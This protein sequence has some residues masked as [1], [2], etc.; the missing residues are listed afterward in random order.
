MAAEFEAPRDQGG[1]NGIHS[2]R[3]SAGREDQKVT[4]TADIAKG[5]VS[6]SRPRRPPQRAPRM[7]DGRSLSRSRSIANGVNRARRHQGRRRGRLQRQSTA[8]LVVT[9]SGGKAKAWQHRSVRTGSS[10]G[11]MIVGA[12]NGVV[13][14]VDVG[15][16]GHG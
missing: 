8:V 11:R 10:L 12:A 14:V 6:P 5:A 16:S 3:V 15:G 7:G 4:A 2:R 9:G 13:G 1:L